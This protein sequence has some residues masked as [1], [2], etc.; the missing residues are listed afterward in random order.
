MIFAKA[1]N[2]PKLGCSFRRWTDKMCFVF[3]SS[4]WTSPGRT[5]DISAIAIL[6]VSTTALFHHQF[7][8]N[9]WIHWVFTVFSPVLLCFLLLP[10]L[11]FSPFGL[12]LTTQNNAENKAQQE[13]RERTWTR[14]KIAQKKN[15][16]QSCCILLYLAETMAVGWSPMVPHRKSLAEAKLQRYH[17]VCFAAGEELNL[18]WGGPPLVKMGEIWGPLQGFWWYVSEFQWQTSI[19]VTSSKWVGGFD[20]VILGKQRIWSMV[21]IEDRYH[22]LVFGL[23]WKADAPSLLCQSGYGFTQ[24]PQCFWWSCVNFLT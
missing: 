22:M 24:W 10:F 5:R 23:D 17:W 14:G 13:T 3:G 21:L 20:C 7:L 11:R 1:P 8:E 16:R 19:F 15:P 6:E 12:C 18:R 2:A 4:A 9:H